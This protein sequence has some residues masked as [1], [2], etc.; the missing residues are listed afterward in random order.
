[1]TKLPIKSKKNKNVNLSSK[2][3]SFWDKD[4]EQFSVI[5]RF[6]D[7]GRTIVLSVTCPPLSQ[8]MQGSLKIATCEPCDL[9]VIQR[10]AVNL[11]IEIERFLSL[12]LLQSLS[13]GLQASQG[14]HVTIF[15][16]LA[17]LMIL[18]CDHME[19][20][21]YVIFLAAEY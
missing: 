20:R 18:A 11:A 3:T 15:I 14:S 19:T 12:R 9:C 8:V 10:H 17:S 1:M 13:Q 2:T 5:Y 4:G 16:I 6:S 7:K 21:L